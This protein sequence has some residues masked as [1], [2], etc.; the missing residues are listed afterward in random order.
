MEKLNV[1]AGSTDWRAHALSNFPCLPF[2]LDGVLLASV[3]GFVQGIKL[4]ECDQRRQ[5]TFALWGKRAKA[6]GEHG[7][8]EY[9]WWA[10]REFIYNSPEHQFLIERAIRAKFQHNE[11]ARLALSA[12]QGLELIHNVGV[13]SPF[14]SL[15]AT[16]FCKILTEIR[17]ELKS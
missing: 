12:T 8:R 4:L 5:E 2:K 9:V 14:T 17:E 15:P 10:G 11:G 7:S 6:A 13:E 16:T 1:I 3:E